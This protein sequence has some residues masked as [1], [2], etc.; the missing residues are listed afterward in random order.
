[1]NWQERT[2]LLI[3]E[4]GLFRL[5]NSS[6]LIAGLGGVGGAAAEMLARSGV[7]N[8]TI[9]DADYVHPTNLNRQILSL[10]SNIGKKKSELWKCRLLDINPHL[11]LEVIDEFIRDERMIDIIDRGYDYVID[12]IDT[13]SPKVFLIFHSVRKKL[14]IVSSM[15]AGGKMDPEQV[16]IADISQSHTCKLALSMRKRLHKLGVFDGVTVVFSG[17]KVPKESILLIDG[18]TNKKSTV[19]T[20]SYM[21][22]IFGGFCASVVIRSLAGQSF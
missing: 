10:K 16:K 1:M 7:G 12:A 21:P 22:N 18:E 2:K 14:P 19:G 11:N 8:M 13:I 3:G 6:V 4:E 17:E 20:I 5:K 15:G 9:V